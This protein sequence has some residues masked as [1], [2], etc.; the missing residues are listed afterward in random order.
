LAAAAAASSSAIQRRS[1]C[2]HCTRV[3]LGACSSD[4]LWA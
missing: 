1:H 4:G 3:A 2:T